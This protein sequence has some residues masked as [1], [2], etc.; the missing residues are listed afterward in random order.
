MALGTLTRLSDRKVSVPQEISVVGF[1]DIAMAA[2]AT[3][4]LTTV[5]LPKGESGR[6]AVDLLL[7]LLDDEEPP[8]RRLS[9]ELIVRGSTGPRT[10]D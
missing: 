6:A 8:V 3:P 2:M 10:P 5:A 4:S 7:A 9:T 1:D